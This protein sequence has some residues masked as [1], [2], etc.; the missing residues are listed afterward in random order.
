MYVKVWF[1]T[2]FLAVVIGVLFAAALGWQPFGM[3]R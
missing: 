2:I 1:A 3:F